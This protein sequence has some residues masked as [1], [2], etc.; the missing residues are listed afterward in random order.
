M[1]GRLRPCEGLLGDRCERR[2]PRRRGR[3]GPP[4]GRRRHPQDTGRRTQ[5]GSPGAA[6]EPRASPIRSG[7]AA[8]AAPSAEVDARV[9]QRLSGCVSCSGSRARRS[10]ARS[11]RPAAPLV[12]GRGSVAHVGELRGEVLE[13]REDLVVT[14]LRLLGRLDR[15]ELVDRR[16]DLGLGSSTRSC[17]LLIALR[18]AWICGRR[19]PVNAVPKLDQDRPAPPS[20]YSS[21]ESASSVVSVVASSMVDCLV[22]AT[23][24]GDARSGRRA[25]AG[26]AESS[27]QFIDLLVRGP[28]LGG[29]LRAAQSTQDGRSGILRLR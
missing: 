17:E 24:A 19:A 26:G 25:R 14:L 16:L 7:S 21:A 5:R 6:G 3:W 9:R 29:R 27:K 18:A 8:G 1:W 28:L 11:P 15:A 12:A 22:V 4:P 2:G 10:A 13:R 23:A 20:A